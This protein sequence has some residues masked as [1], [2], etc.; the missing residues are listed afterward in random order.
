M[1]SFIQ[2]FVTLIILGMG[3]PSLAENYFPNKVLKPKRKLAFENSGKTFFANWV[4]LGGGIFRD[5]NGRESG[6]TYFSW[7][8]TWMPAKNFRV[9]WSLGGILNNV[10]SGTVKLLG[11]ASMSLVFVTQVSPLT[12]DIGGGVQYWDG[13]DEVLPQVKLGIGYRRRGAGAALHGLQL[14]YAVVSTAQVK[15][16]QVL[17]GFAFGL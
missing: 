3:S 1:K 2:L 14:S 15:S 7:T 8:P 6:A 12:F 5:F 9:R 16:H 17:L 13:K 11:D 10:E 4:Q